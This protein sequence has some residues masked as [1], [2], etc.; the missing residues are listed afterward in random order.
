MIHK[1]TDS[2]WVV[3]FFMML[4]YGVLAQNYTV[5]SSGN[6]GVG[7]LRR[8]ISQANIDGPGPHLID[9]NLPVGDRIINLSSSLPPVTV[10]NVTI[11][12]DING[13]GVGDITIDA[14]TGNNGHYIF[15]AWG[16]GN[17]ATFKGF[18]LQDTGYEPF[19]FDGSPTG[20]TIE[21]I[22]AKHTEGDYLN[23][24]I[25]FDGNV[26]GL[27]VNNFKMFNGESAVYGIRVTG[28]ATNVNI[29]NFEFINGSG[30]LAHGIIF[31]GAANNITIQNTTLNMDAPRSI[32][33]VDDGNYG[34]SF[35]SSATNVTI[36]KVN[37][38]DAEDNGIDVR[39]V[40][41]NINI[42]NSTLD[43]LVGW[44]ENIMVRFHS[45]VNN[46]TMT[47]VSIDLDKTGTVNDGNFG[48]WIGGAIN[49]AALTR[50][51]VNAA[52]VDGIAILNAV[53]NLTLEDCTVTGK[54][55]Y[56]GDEDGLE[57][58]NN[59]PRTNVVINNSTFDKNGR[60]GIIFHTVHATSQ[61]SITNNT[62]T[63]N[64]S[65]GQGF[66]I[67]NHLGNGNRDVTISNNIISGNKRDGIYNNESDG[68]NITQNSIH[69]NGG[70]GIN[71][72][73]NG[74]D[75]LEL[76]EGDTAVISQ[77]IDVGGGNFDVTFIV[78][79]FCTNCDIEF[80]TNDALDRVQHGRTY[81]KTETGLVAGVYTRTINSG[82]NTTGFWTTTLKD[83]SRNSSVSEFG[84]SFPIK[85]TFKGPA[86]VN[87]GIG[88]WWRA[89]NG[90]TAT[91]W[92]DYS[93]LGH[94]AVSVSVVTLNPTGANFNPSVAF[95]N[96]Y[97]QH[98]GNPIFSIENNYD[99]IYIFA[100][101]IPQKN[102]HLSI[103]GERSN[104][105]SHPIQFMQW[106]D[107]NLYFDTPY[108][109]RL[110]SGDFE[111]DGGNFNTANLYAGKKTPTTITNYIQGVN[112]GST[113]SNY[114]TFYSYT[115]SNYLGASL[116]AKSN[117]N[118]GLAEVV[119]YKEAS[120]LT[121]TDILKINSYLAFK[122]GI[123][124]TGDYLASDG[125][126][127]MWK[128]AN[129]IGYGND[130]AGIGK[131][132]GAGCSNSN[133]LHQT[134]SKSVNP[135]ALVTI[136][137]GNINIASADNITN[138]AT[139]PI[140]SN[141]SFFSW[142]NN[143]GNT[144]FGKAITGVNVNY[145]M[146]RVW[147]VGKTNNFTN[148]PL[149][150][151]LEGGNTDVYLLVSADASFSSPQEF[152]MS[153]TGNVA[154]NSSDLPDGYYFTFGKS[155]CAPAGVAE[156]LKFWIKADDNILTTNGAAVTTWQ[157]IA[158]LGVYNVNSHGTPPVFYNT[159]STEL[160]NFNPS[161]QFNRNGDLR[162][163][164]GELFAHT[165][166][167]T[168][169]VVAQDEDTG[170]RGL[171]GLG[172]N[173]NDPAIE[174]S[175]EFG[176]NKYRIAMDYANPWIIHTNQIL[177]NGI[178]GGANR[179]PQIFGFSTD[180]N[181]V[182]N[183]IN[184]VDGKSL[185]TIS[186]A[187]KEGG[188]GEGIYIG[189]TE[190]PLLRGNITEVIV[191]N[192]KLV[193]TELQKVESY[194][195]LKYGITLG[196]GTATDYI[197]SDGSNMRTAS[198]NVGFGNDISGIGKDGLTTCTTDQLHQTIS[199]SVNEDAL[200][201]IARGNNIDITTA[202]NITNQTSNPIANDLSFLTWA[203]NNGA[204]SYDKIIN[205]ANVNIRMDRVWKVDK[206]TNFANEPLTL[207][208]EGGNTDVYLLVSADTSFS[209]PQEFPMSATGNVAINSSDL[210]DGYYF[211]FGKS[212]CAP[213]GV[214]ENL[215]FWIKADD[216]ILTT[217]GA[218]VTTWQ[219]IAN[220]GVYNVNS[221]GTPPVFYNT[222]STELINFNPSVQF[223]RN[224]DL[225]QS[226]GELFA[227][228]DPFTAFVVAQD[229]DRGLRG[230]IGLGDNGNDPAIE[231]STEFGVNKY[232]IAMDYANPWIIHTNQ[233]LYNG[234]PGGANRQPQIFGFS[235]DN[236]GV[237]N[238]INHVDGKS[239]QTISD[240]NK[241][242]GIGEGIYI[243]STEDIKLRGS[244]TEVIV[245]NKNL[246]GTE[247]KKVE[248]YLALKYGITL[249]Q[250]TATDYIASDGTNM[251][252]VSKNI[253]FGN[254]ISGIGKDGLTTCT[255]EQLHQTISKSVNDDAR[256]TIATGN[257][258]DV[259]TANNIANRLTTSITN[260]LSF[261]MWSNDDG[262][263]S[264]DQAV[265]APS[266]TSRMG[267]T[268]KVDK[269][270]FADLPLTLNLSA[271]DS[272][273]YLLV[274]TSPTF[275]TVQEFQLDTNGNVNISSG[276]LQD[277]TYFTFGKIVTAPGCVYTGI[278]LW[279]KADD[280]G[281]DWKDQSG[282]SF[283]I[284]KVG[285]PTAGAEINFNPSNNLVNADSYSTITDIALSDDL[286]MFG[287]HL[288]YQGHL[289]GLSKTTVGSAG[290]IDAEEPVMFYEGAGGRKYAAYSDSTIENQKIVY[291]TNMSTTL[292]YFTSLF[293]TGGSTTGDIGLNGR[294]E[295]GNLTIRPGYKVGVG[296]DF[297]NDPGSGL[298]SELI[299]YNKN[300]SNLEKNQI[301]SYLALKYGITIDQ[302]TPT[303]YTA[304][305]PAVKMWKASDN[306]GY[307]KDIFGIGRNDCAELDQ[308]V[309]K[310][311]NPTA[312]LT[313]ALDNDFVS[314]NA[315]ASRTT[316]HTNDLQFLT[317][318]NDGG[319]MT[320][321]TTEMD[322]TQ[323]TRRLTREW[324]VDKT[325][326]FSQPINLKFDGLNGS[327]HLIVDTDGDF[328]AGA[329]NLGALDT[330]GEI[331]G[332]NFT[333]GIYFTLAFDPQD[334]GFTKRIDITE[335]GEVKMVSN[336]I[337]GLK[338]VQ[339][340]THPYFAGD[341][342]NYS[343]NNGYDG[344]SYNNKLTVDY[345][346]IDGTSNFSS[347]SADF[348]TDGDSCAEI[349]Y[350][351]LYWAAAYYEK[352]VDNI[353]DN[354]PER[355]NL[356]VPDTRQDFRNIKFKPPGGS[357]IDITPTS[358]NAQTEVVYN[359]YRDTATNAN[360]VAAE[361]LPYV[362]YADVTNIVKGLPDPN[363]TYTVANVRAGI[364]AH[365]AETGGASAGWVLVIIYKSPLFPLRHFTSQDGF[366]F[367]KDSPRTFKYDGINTPAAPNEVRVKYGT[368]VL[369]GD[370]PYTGDRL[371]IT[372]GG[373]DH[374]IFAAPDNPLDNF[375]NSSITVNGVYNPARNP[376][377]KNTLGFD[378]NMF[379]IPN[380]NNT[381]IGNN[382]T[383]VDFKATTTKDQY[384][385]FLNLLVTES[386]KPVLSVVK[387]VKDKDNNDITGA[388]ADVG[389]ELFYELTIQNQG[390]EDI[391]EAY[392]SDEIPKY[393]EYVPNSIESPGNPSFITGSYDAANKKINIA[394]TPDPL[395]RH[396]APFTVRFRTKIVASC[397]DL[398]D[399]CAREIKNIAKSSY[400][401]K[402]S[403]VSVTDE[404]SVVEQDACRINTIGSSDFTINLG[405]CD[406]NFEAFLCTGT[407]DL[408]AGDGFSTYSW[409]NEANPSV[410]LG[411]NQTLTVSSGGVYKV[412]KTV[413]PV[414]CND[415]ERWTVTAFNTVVNPLI[416]IT[417]NAGI[418]GVLKTCSE[419]AGTV[420][421]FLYLCGLDDKISLD[422][423][424]VNVSWQRLDSTTSCPPFD[425]V[426]DCPEAVADA[427]DAQ[428]KEIA[429]TPEYTVADAGE[430]RIVAEFD[431]NCKIK[432]YFNVFKN[433]LDP[434]LTVIED[435]VCGN[436][437]TIQ[438]QVS[439]LEYEYQLTAP[440]NTVTGYQDSDTFT[441]L[442]VEGD[443]KVSVRQKGWPEKNP[444]IFYSTVFLNNYESKVS[445]DVDSPLCPGEKGEMR[446]H[447]EDG[448][449]QYTYT[450]T[451]ATTGALPSI[452][453]TDDKD[454]TIQLNPDTYT[455]KVESYNGICIDTIE[456]TINP[457]GNFTA[458]AAL[459]KD[460]SCN[461]NYQPDPALP[462]PDSDLFIAIVEVNV[463]G[464]TGA[465]LFSTSN[466]MVP[467][468]DPI[469]LSTNPFQFRFTVPGTY[470]IFVQ[471]GACVIEAGTVIITPYTKLEAETKGNDPSCIGLLGTI[472]VT[473]TAGEGPFKYTLDGGTP[474]GPKPDMNHTFYNV[475]AGEHTI[476]IIDVHGCEHPVLKEIITDAVGITADIDI[477][478]DYKCDTDG[479]S[480]TPEL[481][482]IT[483]S[484]A[485]N[486]NGNYEYSNDGGANFKNTTG[487]F[488]GL[489]AGTYSLYIRDTDSAAC[490]VRLGELT[491][492][493]LQV[494][495]VLDLIPTPLQCPDKDINTTITATAIGTNGATNFE[496][497]I[498]SPAAYSTAF[499]P[500][501]VF[502]LP[503]GETYIF[504]A[505][506]APDECSLKNNI[507]I[508]KIDRI[509]VSNE[510][511]ITKPTCKGDTNGSISF[512]ISGVDL[513]PTGTTYNYEVTGGNIVI[514]LI[515]AGPITITPV[516]I[517]N[518]G[519]GTYVI[520]ATDNT[521][522]CISEKVLTIEEPDIAFDFTTETTKANCGVN[523][524]SITI[525]TIGG[526][527][528]APRYELRDAANTVII[529]YQNLNSFTSLSGGDYIVSVIDGNDP[530]TSCEINKPVTVEETTPPSIA[531]AA[532]G[533]LCYDI[534]DKSSR[535]ITITPGVG[536]VGLY[537][538][539]LNGG[540][541]F[542]AK[543]LP[544]PA[545]PN[546]FEII[547]LIP[548]TYDVMV[549]D[550]TSKC[551][552]T[553]LTFDIKPQLTLDALLTKKLDCSAT[554]EASISVTATG[555]NGTNTFEVNVN[556]AGYV[557]YLGTFPYTTTTSG[558]HWFRVTD[559]EGCTAE[560]KPDPITPAVIPVANAPEVTLNCNGESNGTITIN[561]TGGTPPFEVNF[562]GLGY[563]TD[564]TYSGLAAGT[565][566]YTVK[567][568]KEC[569]AT[570]DV[571]VI[572][573]VIITVGTEN[574][575]DISCVVGVGN[576]PGKIDLSNI[577]GG[578]PPYTY[579]LLKPDNSLATT[580]SINPKGPVFD[581]FVVFNDL[582]FGDYKVKIVD[583]NK[584]TYEFPYTINTASILT[585]N[586]LLGA[587]C[588][589]GV[590]A[591][592][593][594]VGGTGPF[595]IRTYPIG[596][597]GNLSSPPRN[598]QDGPLPFDI[599]FMYEVKDETTL[600]TDIK[601]LI[602]PP[603]PSAIT[604]A[605]VENNV[606][607]K[608][609]KDGS[610]DY[611]IDNYQGTQL[612][613]D[614]RT[615]A[616]PLTNISGSLV[617]SL[618]NPQTVT[619]GG[620][621]TGTVSGLS[622]GEYYFSVRETDGTLPKPCNKAEEFTIKEAG[623]DVELVFVN[624]T[625]TNCKVL[626][627]QVEM[628][629]SGGVPP[630]TYAYVQGVLP[631]PNPVSFP[632]SE[633]RYLD[634]AISLDWVVFVK[635]NYNCI[636]PLQIA[637]PSPSVDP[638]LEPLANLVDEPCK[639][640][641]NYPF[642]AKATGL[643]PLKF[644][645]N[646]G[647]IVDANKGFYEHEFTVTSPGTYTVVAYDVNNCVSNSDTIEVYPELKI[648][649]DFTVEPTCMNLDGEIT[650]TATGGSAPAN[651]SF[652][653]TDNPTPQASG[654]F[655]GVK[656]G[657]YDVTVI[658]SLSGCSVSVSVSRPE[659]VKQ[660]L[661]VEKVTTVSCFGAT[662]G[663][664]LVSLQNGT[665]ID[666]PFTYQLFDSTGTVQIGADQ[667]NNPLFE[668]KP[669]GDY[670]VKVTSNK[671]CIAQ[672]PIITIPTPTT[673]LTAT[674]NKEAYNCDT[675]NDVV[676]PKIIVTILG[677]TPPY[678]ISYTGSSTPVNNQNVTDA[679]G[680][681]P[682]VEYIIIADIAGNYDITIHDKEHC[683][684]I[685]P[686]EN[687][688]PFPIM[689]KLPVNLVS[690][691]TCD[692]PN[693]E[694]VTVSVSR[695]TGN[696]GGFQ[697]DLLPIGTVASQTIP[698]NPSGT[699]STTFNLP[700]PGNYSFRITDLDT[701]C[702]LETEPYYVAPYNTII[703][704]VTAKSD[705]LC[706]GDITG[707]IAL[708]VSGYTGAYNYTVTD[709]ESGTIVVP[710]T[711]AN[712]TTNPLSIGGL[713]GGKYEIEVE[714]IDTPYCDKKTN[715]ATIKSPGS[716]VKVEAKLNGEETCNPGDD[717]SIVAI[718]SG[719]VGDKQYQLETAGGTIVRPYSNTPEFSGLD[720]GDYIVRVKDTNNCEATD[721]ITI[722]APL[723]IDVNAPDS[724]LLCFGDHNGEIVATATGGKGVG[725]YFFKLT[726]PDGTQS[727]EIKSTTDSYTFVNLAFGD[728]VVTVTDYL[729]CEASVDVTI[730]Q[731]TDVELGVEVTRVPGCVNPTA[732]ALV[733]GIGGL[734]PYTFSKDGVIYEGSG[735][736]YTFSNLTSKIYEFYVKDSNNCISKT[737]SNPISVIEPDKLNV[738]LEVSNTVVICY[739]QSTA[740]INATVTGGLGENMY[741]L[742]GKD[743]LG[744]DVNTGPQ[745]ESYFGGLV[746][747]NYSYSVI[748]KDCGPESIPFVI[749]QPEEFIVTAT[750]TDITCNGEKDGKIEV[751]ATGGT[752]NPNSYVYSLYDSA[753]EPI[754]KLIADDYDGI[755]GV[756]VFEEIKEPGTYR[757]E[758]ADGFG[759]PFSVLDLVI[760]EPPVMSVNLID[761][762]PET[763]ANSSDGE[764]TVQILGG[765]PGYYWSLTGV[766]GSFQ[767]VANPD[768]FAIGELP[769]GVITNLFIRDSINS[770]KC[771]YQLEID[772]E[773]GVILN[774]TLHNRLECP[775]VHSVTG[776]VVQNPMYF[777]DFQLGDDSVNTDIE[778]TLKS[779][780]GGLSKKNSNGEFE[781]GPGEYEGFM[782]HKPSGCGEDP[783]NPI[784]AGTI[785]VEGYK[786]LSLPEVKMTGNSYNPNEYE[787]SVNNGSGI[788]T[789]YIAILES[790]M[791]I[792][793]LEDLDFRELDT[794]I[795]SIKKTASY[796]IKV[797]DTSG[798]LVM[799]KYDLTYINIQIEN[800]FTPDGDGINDYWYPTQ[801]SPS[802]SDPFYFPNI[803]V[804]VY[805]RCGRLLEKFVGDQQ[806]WD[807][808]YKGR[809]LPTGDYWFYIELNDVDD[810]KC[811]GHFTLYR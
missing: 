148:Q 39:S 764:A 607:C 475:I 90:A 629:T 56:H 501:N 797:E 112:V 556:G 805:D 589:F 665:N 685:L 186:D 562:S 119:I 120:S 122:Y 626:L 109:Y 313:I 420:T 75:D 298:V 412:V 144:S 200:V 176:V 582:N 105:G 810:R 779:T 560:A 507:T 563:K 180:N 245:Y 401:G 721:S 567:D 171:I 543:L 275:S 160:I 678:T 751:K 613:F 798:C 243:G 246:V 358:T 708:D 433:T 716:I 397:L 548:N 722:T 254:D 192:K 136:A 439:A 268:W 153:A 88:A 668:A 390:N 438:V 662:D 804:K 95:N 796:V 206:T 207:N 321:Q 178:P 227:H 554:P 216:N 421:S 331:T 462:N 551:V 576:K 150:L 215:K 281:I 609:Q 35:W 542:E 599:E 297:W 68:V 535:W 436:P 367:V 446:I 653:L 3:F 46:L 643:G 80:F 676:L 394:I 615:Q 789:Y 512:G 664:I 143:D 745:G 159:T 692:P 547:G 138:Q 325:S 174:I 141:L 199:K 642:T 315:D 329:T 611:T 658:D 625:E 516:T 406:G 269:T 344:S 146:S 689:T 684:Y 602:P 286:M 177:Y 386:V 697:F 557:P 763:C 803:E 726:Y 55:E 235:T 480:I 432:Y 468:I 522:N 505:R 320:T 491:I 691:I 470:T 100:V 694:V 488:S 226:S 667:I 339:P 530:A 546:T 715:S 20:V 612:T 323:Y 181:G 259:S 674:S 792:D 182:D 496:Y 783:D 398:R 545:P 163:S 775:V 25:L 736:S 515:I 497:R 126:T 353:A 484:N 382:Q 458:V 780:S 785:T 610:L 26:N 198:K 134:I 791:S 125:V 795:F 164:S 121:A 53:T 377:S 64:S 688:V 585:I 744:V 415:T 340:Q 77:S 319:A 211:T 34:I 54:L 732:D 283:A 709:T 72:E 99:N 693:A 499:D 114:P 355:H 473:V 212:V 187:N 32:N 185:Q 205:G 532:G 27:T 430:Y 256:V 723:V 345:I 274:S 317:I 782:S 201:T 357:Y 59:F 348:S 391:I 571:E 81:I 273:T 223:N 284:T 140:A 218:A 648:N 29:D 759:C 117:G 635:D 703:A 94:D 91:D 388:T 239:V 364:G 534:A 157:N 108:A 28:T 659:A 410:V 279:L 296:F 194:L 624:A 605:K 700:S 649:A 384:R 255:I 699:T 101:G 519:G 752:I 747:G 307:N 654:V 50:V 76:G 236:N 435:I 469:P 566:S 754:Y 197:A 650:A 450:I 332:I 351:G 190:D 426:R 229:E 167:F 734:P 572:E 790:E 303:D 16:G 811:T 464:G 573:P 37:I 135:D 103:W 368:A 768:K 514:T 152:P 637:I 9:F 646:G 337:I 276:I 310:S 720:A 352:R 704:T 444:C 271:G 644:Q 513:S 651:L 574:N 392:I 773:P 623:T 1:F 104:D 713:T 588:T 253:G 400:K 766:E 154:I 147:K 638:V 250:G 618:G 301:D 361:E 639:F 485:Q 710:T 419:G 608:G 701:S 387:R 158:N 645:L 214:A 21:D 65:S 242:G 500:N 282:N 403:G 776:T 656:A 529:P 753:D 85:N 265:T 679:D 11:D 580:T 260:N 131:D 354:A 247:L 739:G 520:K 467:K 536:S 151:N 334:I 195:A 219:N 765:I 794:E 755:T 287:V 312:V 423:G 241:E 511:V 97:Y 495:T 73:S 67:W 680:S 18:T 376:N 372:N 802:P 460:L 240:A 502:E 767:E 93:G 137:T 371:Y 322:P 196:Q 7:T 346:K 395:G 22:L 777:V 204:T 760:D 48:I 249:G 569:T 737:S 45:A 129:N 729:K 544:A 83:N 717:S 770:V 476:T 333:D 343:P 748:S 652:T 537:M 647:V 363:G 324:K 300:A 302:S 316:N 98:N 447:V 258:V 285:T 408:I 633:V 61:Y 711:L 440:D 257:G 492:A 373:T 448:K 478:K 155:V 17:N 741:T 326:N 263:T 434:T 655:T 558:T 493:P 451:G 156:N 807:G 407:L 237:N 306:V 661:I 742:S 517:P 19:R 379:E 12:G 454:Y 318:A 62:I 714:A 293:S 244:I 577:T 360:P 510:K 481:G 584:C 793:K 539:N 686:T 672:S 116:H 660:E 682:E 474:V 87:T 208:L 757:V 581:N 603:N 630:Y 724:D 441:N 634:P 498:I 453:P 598:H 230:L 418:N 264:F 142:S 673:P 781:V 58:Y 409:I 616:D 422:S 288:G 550:I 762:K 96:S 173:G 525:T 774:A 233:I 570:F 248:S 291:T 690:T 342:T 38:H 718:G 640:D 424:F 8:A 115:D 541:W 416:E 69:N 728:Y 110:N 169:F 380:L 366:L 175:T 707:E 369:E 378:T 559:S 202:N 349:I 738:A 82:G 220:L 526:T 628:K 222:T 578:I 521:T 124:I 489:G 596:V 575:E 224:G 538:Y 486:G 466:T 374:S 445:V 597:F 393:L 733:T 528:S 750:A 531:L 335:Q 399:A 702:Y 15:R 86:C 431:G 106:S 443:Y 788:Y 336:S 681:T 328:S 743:Y 10:S 63:N 604:I 4:S 232:R 60:A 238:V 503:S 568:N 506:T 601:K 290:T 698:E 404:P 308:R 267:R 663:A 149:T 457:P 772:I 107:N 132:F 428:W 801:S 590:T 359:G 338:G 36:D 304:S 806:G 49:T 51:S 587:D 350:A 561:V 591:D 687:I 411:T 145:R 5:T 44:E 111:S 632:D 731:P 330:N 13:D 621:A 746:A 477:S 66:G 705:I 808:T 209:S 600:C 606:T 168:A 527:G 266:V 437:G 696:T 70:I 579:S 524:G 675:N 280:G 24:G 228:T 740:S 383:F 727:A 57:F 84:N 365:S 800:N 677:G 523:E 518:L 252:T 540:A 472:E 295:S 396:D 289:I 217:N 118:S 213:A 631:K 758:V 74:N 657:I 341:L 482:E 666:S 669:A 42:T 139:N 179:Q 787:I 71:N 583:K 165:D 277:G 89:D 487:V 170:V 193:G 234:I 594:V 771:Q 172:D 719:G 730:A 6:D 127:N 299:I 683:K 23:N 459:K 123:T 292:P 465:Y 311:V 43:N 427:C 494:V 203:N 413:D 483:I 14:G 294:V 417:E 452:G 305:D 593:E 327:Y 225:R 189:S 461:P 592:L 309:S 210:P 479:S 2:L 619:L 40:A 712:T 449:A 641:N 92:S 161:V 456:K 504:E 442:T 769:G 356:P 509:Q 508:K 52:D 490:P 251:W 636:K 31:V 695:V 272:D 184:H 414:S 262:S 552:T 595:K 627:S 79:D 385:I 162:Q 166:P 549:R 78:P 33:P 231:I 402:D 706:F 471:D 41:T 784:S 128:A 778:Y 749:S 314:S 463:V 555:G 221:H 617:F 533:D 30:N 756:H 133:L 671:G 565:Y 389:D 761:K 809:K 429:T 670:I 725:N 381:V 370:K 586:A 47:D 362:C 102:K 564:L 622:P 130:I 620:T 261:L 270:N 375:Y 113:T 553:T 799:K 614:I 405:S 278:K 425:Y 183:V 188:I 735:V 455:I 347:S 191:Y 786:P